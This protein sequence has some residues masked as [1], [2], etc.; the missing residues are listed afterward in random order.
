MARDELDVV[1]A[2][3]QQSWVLIRPCDPGAVLLLIHI[4]QYILVVAKVVAVADRAAVLLR[5]Q[6]LDGVTADDL[7]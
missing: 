6:S 5:R 7:V 2:A 1:A 4:E 3:D